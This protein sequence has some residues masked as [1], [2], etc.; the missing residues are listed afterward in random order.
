MSVP[1]RGEQ[2]PARG[3]ALV[4]LGRMAARVELAVAKVRV[5]RSRSRHKED[6]KVRAQAL[7]AKGFSTARVAE[8]RNAHRKA[9]ISNQILQSPFDSPKPSSISLFK[10]VSNCPLRL[11]AN[12]NVEF[13]LWAQ[14]ATLTVSRA[15]TASSIFASSTVGSLQHQRRRA[16]QDALGRGHRRHCWQKAQ[17][18]CAAHVATCRPCC[19]PRPG[20]SD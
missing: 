17:V 4:K 16:G 5:S 10:C 12:E 9:W 8:S 14:P 13:N 6:A 20:L 2:E 1:W 7:S 19:R 3:S 15:S 18:T 11:S